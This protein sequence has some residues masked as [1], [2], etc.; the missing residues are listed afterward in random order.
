MGCHKPFK[1]QGFKKVL[2]LKVSGQG[3]LKF[4]SDLSKM[5]INKQNIYDFAKPV[6][7]LQV[8]RRTFQN[9]CKINRK[10]MVFTRARPIGVGVV[11]PVGIL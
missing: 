2:G 7:P 3:K 1:T 9:A 8:G 4:E 10:F 6:L 5:I 11:W